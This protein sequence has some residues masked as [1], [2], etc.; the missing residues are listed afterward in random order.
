MQ[1]KVYVKN[2]RLGKAV[3]AKDI[4]QRGDRVLD[5]HGPLVSAEATIQKGPKHEGYYLQVK[6]KDDPQAYIYP[7]EPG[8]SV[9]HSCS[10]NAGIINDTELTALADIKKGEEITFDYSTTMDEDCWIMICK[11]G[12]NNCRKIVND[13]KY[14]AKDIQQKYLDQGIVQNFIARQYSL[15]SYTFRTL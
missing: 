14:L 12:H 3:F 7:E 6:E 5:F 10:P 15:S 9:N 1:E 8:R 2:S 4:I 13:F 11:C